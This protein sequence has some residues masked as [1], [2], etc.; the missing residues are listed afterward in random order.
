MPN[1]D[2]SSNLLHL[3]DELASI[4]RSGDGDQVEAVVLEV[5]AKDRRV[6][7]GLKQLE[8]N[9]W[10][11]IESRY[12]VGSVVEGR[13]RN[14][15][16]VPHMHDEDESVAGDA[17]GQEENGEAVLSAKGARARKAP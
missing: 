9:P 16:D 5:H 4:H 17:N 2:L 8:P 6:S 13:V 14:M 12:S 10:T 3:K 7:L 11:T 1:P 15:T